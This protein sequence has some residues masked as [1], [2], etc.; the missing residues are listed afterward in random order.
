MTAFLENPASRE[1]R[2]RGQSASDF[3][4]GIEGGGEIVLYIGGGC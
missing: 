1:R 3:G 4:G 2:R